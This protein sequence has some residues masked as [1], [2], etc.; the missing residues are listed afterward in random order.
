MP[1][2]RDELIALAVKHL[3]LVLPEQGPYVA[4][5]MKPDG[6]FLP[7][8]FAETVEELCDKLQRQ[9]AVG[10][11]AY[12]AIA[13]FKEA[14][15]DPKGTPDKEKQYGRTEKNVRELRCFPLDIDITKHTNADDINEH[16]EKKKYE[17]QEEALNAFLDFCRKLSLPLPVIINSGY[18]WHVYWALTKSISP[19]LWKFHMNGLRNLCKQHGLKVDFSKFTPTTV[20]RPIGSHNRK[21]GTTALVEVGEGVLDIA[22]S[23][24]DAFKIFAEN[25]DGEDDPRRHIPGGGSHQKDT[26][27]ANAY[28]RSGSYPPAY[29]SMIVEHCA[30]IRRMRDTPNH[31]WEPI[32]F[33]GNGVLKFCEDGRERT[34]EWSAGDPR[35]NEAET[36][37]KLERWPGPT[38]CKKFDR[39]DDNQP[40]LCRQCRFWGKIKS[41]IQITPV[42]EE[43]AEIN[44]EFMFIR[45]VGGKPRIGKFVKNDLGPGEVLELSTIDSLRLHLANCPSAIIDDKSVFTAWMTSRDRRQ[46]EGICMRPGLG[47]LVDGKLN[48]YRGLAIKPVKGDW[49]LLRE[50]IENIIA[51]GRKETADY[52][53]KWSA[54]AVQNPG[55]VPEVALVLRGGRG[56]GKGKFFA[57]LLRRIFGA[58]G[59]HLSQ[60]E[61]FTGKFNA[62]MRSCVLLVVDEAYWAGDKQAEAVLKALITESV[63]TLEA[64]HVDSTQWPNCLHIIILANEDWVV[65][66]GEDERRYVKSDVSD[67][68]ANNKCPPE[69][70]NKYFAALEHE[71]EHGGLEAM[72]YDLLHMKLAAEGEPTPAPAE[73]T[74][75][76]VAAFIPN[77]M[78]AQL[79][80]RGLSEDAIFNMKPQEAHDFLSQPGLKPQGVH[81]LLPQPGWHPR[82]IPADDG[83]RDQKRFNLKPLDQWLELTLQDGELPGG[84]GLYA[85]HLHCRPLHLIKAN[86]K[87]RISLHDDRYTNDVR[88]SEYLKKQGIFKHRTAEVNLWQFPPLQKMRA[89]WERRFGGWDWDA[90]ISEWRI[91]VD[92]PKPLHAATTGEA[93][94]GNVDARLISIFRPARK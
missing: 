61:Q 10:R 57:H 3:R 55:S 11:T 81:D 19:E 88:L 34:L 91:R 67:R 28:L 36:L 46:Y 31:L 73:G 51:G 35:F 18:G 92:P 82:N 47:E 7:N 29:V 66:A 14:K 39:D 4:T 27:L 68:Y 76:S 8:L 80:A 60:R 1:Y 24:L 48:L 6:V 71:I 54:W 86:I 2:S 16:K 90:A 44:A 13:A 15:S 37:D 69:E 85:E 33:D 25:S 17:S 42:P 89:D 79:Q 45:S 20:L 94:I 78:K 59:M 93:D 38:T 65:P 23:P 77:S 87:V 5:I 53:I 32:W 75:A 41:P 64:K 62:H 56:A 63:L 9:D 74:L 26:L 70:R 43:I 58:H 72:L 21:Y 84:D 22:P 12:F 52:I 30:Q 50:H 49:H 83:L 40:S